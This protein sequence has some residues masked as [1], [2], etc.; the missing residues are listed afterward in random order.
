MD[1]AMQVND[2]V[3]NHEETGIESIWGYEEGTVYDV[4]YKHICF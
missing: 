4:R 3:L 2:Y 1:Y